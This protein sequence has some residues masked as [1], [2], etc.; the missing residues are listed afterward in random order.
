MHRDKKKKK[1]QNNRLLT[2]KTDTCKIKVTIINRIFKQQK[3]KVIRFSR[4]QDASDHDI[5]RL[6]LNN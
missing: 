3:N 4:T 6:L 1:L 5:I 2:R